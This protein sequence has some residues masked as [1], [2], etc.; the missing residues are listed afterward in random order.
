MVARVLAPTHATSPAIANSILMLCA[1]LDGIPPLPGLIP[2]CG[3]TSPVPTA[4]PYS[5]HSVAVTSER[6]EIMKPN[7][8]RARNE[9]YQALRRTWLKQEPYERGVLRAVR[10]YTLTVHVEACSETSGNGYDGPWSYCGDDFQVGRRGA[11]IPLDEIW[12][13]SVARPY[14]SQK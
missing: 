6:N 8:A 3:R 9:L 10:A 1:V 11:H 13:C 4:W 2:T 7:K 14:L 12:Y 5:H